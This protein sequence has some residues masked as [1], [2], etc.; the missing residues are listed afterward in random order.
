MGV[1]FPPLHPVPETKGFLVQTRV[2]EIRDAEWTDRL[3]LIP[4]RTP[5][6]S[7]AYRR[8][9]ASRSALKD[10]EPQTPSHRGGTKHCSSTSLAIWTDFSCF[11][12]WEFCSFWMFFLMPLLWLLYQFYEPV[13]EWENWDNAWDKVKRKKWALSLSSLV[14]SPLCVFPHVCHPS[15]DLLELWQL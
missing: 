1:F 10:P 3:S 4:H 6:S 12:K 9:H 14:F 11:Y 7:M 13:V 15:T 8:R 5:W 2:N